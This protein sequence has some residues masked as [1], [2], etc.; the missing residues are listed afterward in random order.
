MP[1]PVDRRRVAAHLAVIM[2]AASWK[3]NGDAEK[4]ESRVAVLGL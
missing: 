2:T 4:Y 3:G 1:H